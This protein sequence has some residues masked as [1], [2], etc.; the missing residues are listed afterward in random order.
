MFIVANY[1]F[2]HDFGAA[3]H[4]CAGRE[5]AQP[6]PSN[7]RSARVSDRRAW[8]ATDLNGDGKPDLV[9][10]AFEA[11]AITVLLNTRPRRATQWSASAVRGASARCI[12]M[13]WPPPN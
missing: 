11:N 5:R 2:Q 8:S 3:Q 13:R 7:R 6:S 1:G 10:T 4:D 9:V 12:L